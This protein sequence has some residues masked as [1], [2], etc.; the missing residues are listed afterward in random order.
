VGQVWILG[1]DLATLKLLDGYAS[2]QPPYKKKH[3]SG[4]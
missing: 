1:S 3:S 2:G 4:V